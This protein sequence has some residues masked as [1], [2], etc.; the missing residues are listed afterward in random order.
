MPLRRLLAAASALLTLQGGLAL[1]QLGPGPGGRAPYAFQPPPRNEAGRFDYYTLVLSWSPTYCAS[2][3]R[4][5]YDPQ[6]HR[7]DGKRYSFVLHGLWPQHE[8]GWPE[9]C[10]TRERPF[11]PQ[12]TIERMLDIMP[13]PRLVIHEYRKHGTCSG[14]TPEG[15][16]DFSRKLHAKVKVPAR[17]ERPNQAFFVSPGE[18]VQDFLGANPGLKSDMLA[19][20]CGGPG[21]RLREIRICFSREGEYR[22]CGRNEEPR[23]LCS[24]DRMFV[25]PVREAGGQAQP[26]QAPRK[27]GPPPPPAALPRQSPPPGPEGPAS[28][29]RGERRI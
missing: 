28:P 4:D 29:P 25:P 22:A 2:L 16:Y 12:A 24:S 14:M 20:G 17:Y 11:V 10:P 26:P 6:C 18:L 19:V 7:R 13:S 3:P 9:N 15:Y 1:A 23:R 5:G 21:G 27:D 8:R